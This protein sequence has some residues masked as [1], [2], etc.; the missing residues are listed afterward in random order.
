MEK[1]EKKKLKGEC[2]CGFEF[3][4]PHGENDAVAVMQEHVR[5][6]HEDDYPNGMSREEALENIK[7]AK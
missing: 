5:R 7:E 4:T 1:A 2:P 3:L 6:I